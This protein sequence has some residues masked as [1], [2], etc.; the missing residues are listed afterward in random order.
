MVNLKGIVGQDITLQSVTA[1]FEAQPD[2]DGFT[3]NSPGGDVDT[4]I[5]VFMYL[6]GKGLKRCIAVGECSSIATLFPLAVPVEGREAHPLVKSVFHE[7]RYPKL[8][9]DLTSTEL[10]YAASHLN[11]IN[12]Q[13]I[14]LYANN[15][16][17]TADE[18]REIIR[19]QKAFGADELVR[20]G[21]FGK[22]ASIKINM[23][24]KFL[25][26][27]RAFVAKAVGMTYLTPDG[28]E[29]FVDEESM[30]CYLGDSVCPDG[31]H[32]GTDGDGKAVILVVKDGKLLEVKAAEVA[33]DDLIEDEEKL[34]MVALASKM[35]D[36]M[37]ALAAENE[38]L[39]AKIAALEAELATTKNDAKAMAHQVA[40]KGKTVK[41]IVAPATAGRENRTVDLA[42]AQ[43]AQALEKSGIVNSF[44]N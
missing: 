19:G 16:T 13:F 44:K 20:I 22:K 12:D 31:E 34:E 30:E 32:K 23:F 18:W 11:V 25:K 1:A 35:A 21:M 43:M 36:K 17:L 41:T 33:Q 37:A 38:K 42:V 7:A 8:T 15:S 14:D 2:A 5:D 4:G 40:Q 6:Q 26:T 9:G 28:A 39:V 24:Q 29:I 10:A 27:M 3:I